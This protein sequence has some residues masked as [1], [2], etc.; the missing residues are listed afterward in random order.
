MR[1]AHEPPI[2]ALFVLVCVKVLDHLGKEVIDRASR[3]D[4][5]DSDGCTSTLPAT[6]YLAMAGTDGLSRP[7]KKP[8]RRSAHVQVACEMWPFRALP[9]FAWGLTHERWRRQVE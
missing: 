2:Y 9:A 7:E 4:K 1:S 3:I 8:N 6:V 5:C